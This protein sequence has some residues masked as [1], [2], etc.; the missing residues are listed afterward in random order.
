MSDM[1]KE[2]LKQDLG[3]LEKQ[4]DIQ[5]FIEDAELLGHEDIVNLAKEKLQTITEKAKSVE[6]T[7]DSQ[8]SQVNEFG[9]SVEEVEK[10]TEQV[11]KKIEE[12]ENETKQK[13]ETIVGS[14]ENLE[15][16]Y[17]P[18][19]KEAINF[20]EQEN[21][22]AQDLLNEQGFQ[23]LTPE[24][25]KFKSYNEHYG[26]QDK[27]SSSYH[28]EERIKKFVQLNSPQNESKEQKSEKEK[29]LLMAVEYKELQ[30][31]PY[32]K[33]Q[34]NNLSFEDFKKQ[35]P[36]ILSKVR[37]FDATRSQE[38]R[39]EKEDNNKSELIKKYIE[40][41]QVSE[42]VSSGE[43]FMSQDIFSQ[44]PFI[45]E[46][47]LENNKISSPDIVNG[48][49]QYIEKSEQK[50]KTSG[51]TSSSN[52]SQRR[53]EH[54]Q[55][56]IVALGGR[57][58]V[59]QVKQII[60]AGNYQNSLYTRIENGIS[61][62]KTGELYKSMGYQSNLK[63]A[64]DLL[65]DPSQ[66]Q[67]FKEKF[68]KEPEELYVSELTQDLNDA[69]NY[70]NSRENPRFKETFFAGR[71]FSPGMDGYFD[72]LF[73]NQIAPREKIMEALK[74]S[75]DALKFA[76]DRKFNSDVP[77]RNNKIREVIRLNQQ[78]FITNEEKAELLKP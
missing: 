30:E 31:H 43:I 40:D 51:F 32:F 55:N 53:Q 72:E 56:I 22:I 15:I 62:Y 33:E 46:K 65:T 27:E 23:T 28:L 7:P 70:P 44:T 29:N 67:K 14:K 1:E 59:Q 9:G 77:D 74:K 75:V 61:R 57:M 6:T 12:V 34:Y 37:F 76:E 5:K 47:L 68:G 18:E 16:E 60:E 26:T 41:P 2:M 35:E 4:E 64:S 52:E 54:L 58:S 3:K 36:E 13:I 71:S 38:S 63:E 25:R 78:G 17:S 69:F 11:D 42:K 73:K 45:L 19:V 10:R 48:I 21:K 39:I 20:L 8:L 50:F 49:K 24:T 66:K